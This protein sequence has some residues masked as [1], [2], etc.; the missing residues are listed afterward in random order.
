MGAK[1]KQSCCTVSNYINVNDQTSSDGNTGLTP[2][3]RRRLNSR[4]FEKEELSN[5]KEPEITPEIDFDAYFPETV[6]VISKYQQL[7]GFDELGS[8]PSGLFY[9]TQDEKVMPIVQEELKRVLPDGY[10]ENL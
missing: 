8:I 10:W 6:K 3:K 9:S 5:Y 7:L 2:L 4:M 1:V